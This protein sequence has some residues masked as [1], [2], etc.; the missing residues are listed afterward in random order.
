[1]LKDETNTYFSAELNN[2]PIRIPFL[3]NP[4]SLYFHRF[5]RLAGNRQVHVWVRNKVSFVLVG[6]KV[7]FVSS[8]DAQGGLL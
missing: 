4:I 5:L 8:S 6:D 1:M 2:I 7:T 3:F